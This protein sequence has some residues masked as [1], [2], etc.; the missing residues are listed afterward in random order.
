MTQATFR[1][2][3]ARTTAR[4]CA[5]LLTAAFA[6]AIAGG[7]ASASE[8]KK[9]ESTPAPAKA[10]GPKEVAVIKTNMGTIVFEFLPDVAP[11]MVENFKG[12]ARSGFYEGTTF[13]RVISG[14]MIQ[15]GDP[16]SKKGGGARTPNVPAE[17]TT[18]YHHVRGV[19]STA[20]LPNDINSGSSQ[21]FIMHRDNLGLDN[22]YTIFGKVIEGMD[23]VDKIAAV[24]TS[25]PGDKPLQDVVMEKVT[26]ETR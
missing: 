2:R 24:R 10:A 14:F 8:E 6:L 26:I 9:M 21:F 7:G 19:V 3:G 17:F 18:K 1:A 5:A 4:A 16:A 20:R 13:H 12:L 25:K 22:Q 15:G 23:T 11:K